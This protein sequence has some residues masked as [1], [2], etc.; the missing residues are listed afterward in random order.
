MVNLTK[1]LPSQCSDLKLR[2]T[3]LDLESLPCLWHQN[4]ALLCIYRKQSSGEF[5]SPQLGQ[6][7]SN[8]FSWHTF[9]SFILSYPFRNF[10]LLKKIIQHCLK[11]PE[12]IISKMWLLKADDLLVKEKKLLVQ[13]NVNN[14]WVKLGKMFRPASIRIPQ[15][16]HHI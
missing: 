5:N 2:K 12:S 13:A 16:K 8:D 9:I 14:I 6:A 4:L 15:L 11:N 7:Y 1:P 3:F 10:A